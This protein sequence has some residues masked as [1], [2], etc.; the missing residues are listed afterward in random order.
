VKSAS[1]RGGTAKAWRRALR[2]GAC[3]VLLSGSV[4]PGTAACADGV[5][6][7]E[8]VVV[9]A[10]NPADAGSAC[11]A[12]A[13][14]LV[15]LDANGLSTTVPIHVHVVS[16]LPK[17]TTDEAMGCYDHGHRQIHLLDLAS[18][19]SKGTI[20]GLPADE[21]LHRSVVV[22][23]VAHAAAAAKF[24]VAMPALAAQEYIACVAQFAVL[25]QTTR[26]RILDR[27]PG[28]GFETTAAINS[29]VFLM[30]PNYFAAQAWRH[31]VKPENGV[32]FIRRLL[33]GE[34]LLDFGY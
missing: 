32:A 7:P 31:F 24:A 34:L 13:D 18:C 21:E 30:D 2:A 5:R 27:H 8:G 23:E 10:A 4:V 28:T 12:A 3:G 9:T 11:A 26:E 15:L 20:L 29:T 25:S 22:H 16:R 6:C 17:E 1:V 19:R 33:A 14:A